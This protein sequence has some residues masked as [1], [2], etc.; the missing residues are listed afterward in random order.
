MFGDRLAC[1]GEGEIFAPPAADRTAPIRCDI[2][3]LFKALERAVKRG[4]FERIL[5]VAFLL[6]FGNDLVAVFVTVVERTQDDCVDMTADQIGTDRLLA[7]LFQYNAVF[8][9]LLL[10]NLY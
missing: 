8:H 6:D 9:G 7:A 5:P 3:V 4:L 2:A 10:H 1:L